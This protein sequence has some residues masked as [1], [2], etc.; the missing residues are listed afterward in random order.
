[1]DGVS[2]AFAVVSLAIQLAETINDISKFLH[3]VRDAPAELA[4]LVETLDQMHGTVDQVRYLL[5]QQFSVQ[6]LPGSPM[7]IT[8]ALGLCEKRV[9][10][11]EAFVNEV[12]RPLTNE[13]RIKRT[14]L[15]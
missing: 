4:G 6:R 3:S 14:W 13:H 12:K 11:L 7:F 1:M 8:S 2:S 9:K 10:T 5:E 15:P